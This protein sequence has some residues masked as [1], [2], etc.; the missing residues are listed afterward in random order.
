MTIPARA[1]TSARDA[2]DDGA[3]RAEALASESIS[4]SEPLKFAA[5]LMRAQGDVAAAIEAEQALRA[6]TGSLASDV[7]RLL[8]HTLDIAR[9]AAENGPDELAGVAE[10]RLGGSR[11]DM[12]RSLTLFWSGEVRARDDY[13]SRAMLRPFVAMLRNAG[14]A[15]DRVHARGQCPFCGGLPATSCRRG[16][17]ESEGG[18]RLLCCALCGLESSFNRILCP[19]CFEKEPKKLPIFARE[20]HPSARIEACETCGRYVKSIDTSRDIRAIPEIDDV[21]TI[22]LDLWAVEQG[23]TRIEPGL[24]GL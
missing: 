4:A 12:Q 20:E 10:V 2:F 8:P 3:E 23:Y 24:A 13:L 17:S 21:A 7:E 6:F 18:A 16:G 15:P 5:G 1:S 22:A 19:A 14:V 9:F 11:A